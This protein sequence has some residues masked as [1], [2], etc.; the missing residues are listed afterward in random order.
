[1][2]Q[3][4]FDVPALLEIIRQRG[5]QVCKSN[6]YTDYVVFADGR[7]ACITRI[8]FNYAILADLTETFYGDRW[9][10]HHYAL[11]RAAL[12]DWIDKGGPE[13]TIHWH[14]HPDTG[15]RRPDG[16]A[17]REYVNF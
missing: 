14:R 9:C 3:P 4:S 13:P 11:A 7:D 1:M 8:G 12:A 6:G 17:S 2:E 16:D 10:F 15:R 5:E